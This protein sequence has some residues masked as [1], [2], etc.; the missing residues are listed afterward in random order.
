MYPLV[1]IL[2]PEKQMDIAMNPKKKMK[3]WEIMS[4]LYIENRE[5]VATK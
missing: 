2:I 3:G 5:N 4:V 1:D